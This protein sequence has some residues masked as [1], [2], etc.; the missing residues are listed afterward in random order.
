[1]RT[2]SIA[3]ALAATVLASP[4]AAQVTASPD[5]IVGQIVIPDSN[6]SGV[7]YAGTDMFVGQGGFGAGAQSITRIAADGSATTVVTDLNSLGDMVYD[8]AGDRLL[9][10]DNAFESAGATTG[11]TL[12][13]LP[14]PRSAAAP[15]SAATLELLA[16]GSITHAA[17][18]L[19]LPGGSVLVS[20]PVGNDVGKIVD[21]TGGVA[22]DFV[23]GLDYVSGLARTATGDLLVG[24]VDGMT[25]EGRVLKFEADGDPLAPLATGLSG[26][27]DAELDGGGNL[28]VSGGFTPTFSSSTLVSI[29][30]GGAVTEIASGYGFTGALAI[31]GPSGQ[32]ASLDF[33]LA[34]IDTLTPIA[35]LT[36]GGGSRSKKECQVEWWGGSPDLS[37]KGFPKSRWSCSDGAACDR[38]GDADGTCTF[39][40]GACFAVV[41]PRLTQCPAAT[42]DSVAVT[43]GK[44]PAAAASLQTAVDAVLPAA[45]AAC[46]R[47][48][49]V[50][51]PL[52]R[53]VTIGI[54]SIVGG[55]R[56][57]RDRLSLRC[58]P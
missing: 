52:G 6:T 16:S 15:V 42:V 7:A 14:A 4:A 27:Y 39:L 44:A 55:S 51:V 5:Y 46:S 19:L 58:R 36:P 49:I 45:E 20:N 18:L 29:T 21:V 28:I 37:S 3:L 33:G 11:D 26:S 17:N 56:G 47:P 25:F 32:I 53:K 1:M 40:V 8:A 30:P 50:T 22:T 34:A 57:D 35:G 13:A 43:S 10:T 23:T 38:D 12:Y 24:E 54:K 41:D 9:F 48:T 31:D 2:F